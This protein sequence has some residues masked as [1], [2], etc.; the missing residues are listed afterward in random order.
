MILRKAAITVTLLF[1]LAVSTSAQGDGP[2]KFAITSGSTFSASG[3]IS[4][5]ATIT[6]NAA[7]ILAVGSDVEELLNIV[8]INHV[9]GSKLRSDK[10]VGSAITSMLEQLDP[11]SNYFSPEE[12]RELTDGHHGQYVGIGTTIADIEHDGASETFV[13]AVKPNSP[14]ER[15]GLRF[16]DRIIGVDGKAVFGLTSLEVR[17]MVRGPIGTITKLTVERADGSIVREIPIKRDRVVERSV[18]TA[19]LLDTAAGYISLTNGFDYSTYSEFD[20]AFRTLKSHGM[21]SLIIDLKRYRLYC[22]LMAARLRRL[23]S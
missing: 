18:S 12:F 15:A 13:L 23:R 10:L 7:P 2:G 5:K 4:E 8:R 11:H 20:T 6:P 1:A 16:G 14:A 19:L 9:S 17:N 22:L 21:R 3:K